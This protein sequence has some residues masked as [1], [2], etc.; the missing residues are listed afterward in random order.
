[1]DAPDRRALLAEAAVR[2]VARDG[3]RGLTH[4]AVDAEAGLPV[5]SASNVFRSR[6]ALL[7]G[8]GTRL[9]EHDIASWG[10]RPLHVP[11]SIDELAESVARIAALTC[12][13]DPGILRARFAVFA[14]VPSAFAAHHR[15]LLGELATMLSALGVAEP[16]ARAR[17]V[18]D[19][20][21]GAMLHAVTVRAQEPIDVAALA[22]SVRALLAG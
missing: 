6:E 13:R 17:A 2:V 8:I 3:L 15:L 9:V 12:E 16:G 11:A 10:G 18:A 14:G 5:G 19:L 1:M 7:G 4:R 21:D 22:R 20:L